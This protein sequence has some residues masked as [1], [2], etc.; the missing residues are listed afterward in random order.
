MM[1]DCT[2]YQILTNAKKTMFNDPS[3]TDSIETRIFWD[4]LHNTTL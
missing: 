4:I 1:N 3:N 2:E